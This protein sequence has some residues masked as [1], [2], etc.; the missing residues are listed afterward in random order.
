MWVQFCILIW[1]NALNNG[2]KQNVPHSGWLSGQSVNGSYPSH[3]T[4]V[5]HPRELICKTDVNKTDCRFKR[6]ALILNQDC[7]CAWEVWWFHLDH[8]AKNKNKDHTVQPSLST[9]NPIGAKPKIFLHLLSGISAT[10]EPSALLFLSTLMT[11]CLAMLISSSAQHAHPGPKPP[12]SPCM[13]GN[14][15]LP[16]THQHSPVCNGTLGYTA[17]LRLPREKRLPLFFFKSD[18]A[19]HLH[20]HTNSPLTASSLLV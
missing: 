10:I 1:D 11:L 6:I 18:T 8:Q 4:H 19:G 16:D 7:L 3:L 17:P 14:L 12:L 15:S 20:R 13:S 9:L 5:P 2:S